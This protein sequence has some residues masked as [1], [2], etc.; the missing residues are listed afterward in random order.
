[1]LWFDGSWLMRPRCN[2]LVADDTLERN[3]DPPMAK[4][5][6][7]P[8]TW[9]TVCSMA[10]C[11]ALLIAAEFLPVSLLTPI[12]RDLGAS[13]GALARRS[14]YPVCSRSVS[15]P[16]LLS[17]RTVPPRS[18]SVTFSRCSP[19]CQSRSPRSRYYSSVRATTSGALA[20]P[21]SCGECS[22][23]P[24]QLPGRPGSQRGLA[25]S[26]RAVAV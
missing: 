12:A 18:S 10:L 20:W 17:A 26:R 4:S 11:V 21:W 1:M 15:E 6:A 13:D 16:P 23:R 22:T 24:F 7:A 8:A 2:R 9:S 5:V 14:L 3:D 19:A 25:P